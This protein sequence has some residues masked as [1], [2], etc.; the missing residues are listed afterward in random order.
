MKKKGIIIGL[1]TAL[2]LSSTVFAVD[3]GSVINDALEAT[4][5]ITTETVRFGDVDFQVPT[6]YVKDE[7]S[8]DVQLKYHAKDQKVDLTFY[9]GDYTNSSEEFENTKLDIVNNIVS[10]MP[11]GKLL[12][13]EDSKLIGFDG[14]RFDFSSTVDG[15]K[16]DSYGGYYYNDRKEKYIIILLSSPEEVDITDYKTQ[17]DKMIEKAKIN[18]EYIEVYADMLR[19]YGDVLDAINNEDYSGAMSGLADIYSALGQVDG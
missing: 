9:L 14:I 12:K 11:D 15:A 6:F 1:C 10:G 4:G 7:T 17:Y 3:L 5:S 19:N 18:D 2:I 8:T 16:H 13:T